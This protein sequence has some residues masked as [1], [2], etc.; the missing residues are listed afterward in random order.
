MGGDNTVPPAFNIGGTIH[1]FLVCVFSKR[2]YLMYKHTKRIFEPIEIKY[3]I[4][5]QVSKLILIFK[6]KYDKI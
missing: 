4:Q 6:K 5:I 2:L 3:E 1:L